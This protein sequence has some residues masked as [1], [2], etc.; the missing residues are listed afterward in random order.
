MPD[1][2]CVSIVKWCKGVKSLV[3]QIEIVP[4]NSATA[5][6]DWSHDNE[7]SRL[8]DTADGS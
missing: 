4:S 6:F 1:P 3:V 2:G 5:S 8:P 7:I